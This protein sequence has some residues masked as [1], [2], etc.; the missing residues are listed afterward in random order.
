MCGATQQQ[1]VPL[2]Y[3][4]TLNRYTETE[5]ERAGT[6]AD[7][8][9]GDAITES[10][11]T[12][13]DRTYA[14]GGSTLSGPTASGVS[15]GLGMQGAQE[16]PPV[17]LASAD[18][19]VAVQAAP[20]SSARGGGY[21]VDHHGRWL[22]ASTSTTGATWASFQ[23]APCPLRCT[24]LV[25][26]FRC[27]VLYFTCKLHPPKNIFNTNTNTPLMSLLTTTKQTRI[28]LGIAPVPSQS[29]AKRDKKDGGRAAEVLVGSNNRSISLL[30]APV[31][32]LLDGDGN[33]GRGSVALVEREWVDCHRGSVYVLILS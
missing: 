33:G 13:D 18:P 31:S 29:G 14:T 16:R 30:A 21:A 20:S 7:S 25:F 12:V 32:A 24:L 9:F 22:H 6:E 26:I 8:I 27:D 4:H 15:V 1:N 17:H 11:R 2:K 5:R 23:R 3:I 19:P 28:Y 10:G